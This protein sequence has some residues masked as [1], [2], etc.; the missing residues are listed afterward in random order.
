MRRLRNA[1]LL[2]ALLAPS[3]LLALVWRGQ[4]D[5]QRKLDALAA[6]VAERQTPLPA[7]PQPTHP[8]AP[9]AVPIELSLGKSPRP[10]YVI[11]APDIL[12]IEAEVKDAT[13]G[14]VTRLPEQ[15]ISG[16]FIVRPDGTVSLG[17]W[18]AVSVS[19]LTTEQATA[20]IRKQ[21]TTFAEKWPAGSPVVTVNV[22]SNSKFYYIITDSA[23]GEQVVRVPYTGSETVLDAVANVGG[24]SGGIGGR[25]MWISRPG[26][27]SDQVLP[28]D[29]KA[30]TQSGVTATNY[31]LFPGDRLHVKHAAD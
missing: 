11:E 3:T 9:G 8:P 21:L 7:A 25:K 13:T 18:G 19:G 10:P 27:A 26:G 4:L 12:T 28:I 30:I 1:V 23:G 16:T 24:L 22:Q 20:A 29:W 6:A 17:V 14:A 15:P 5:T 2:A 31:Q